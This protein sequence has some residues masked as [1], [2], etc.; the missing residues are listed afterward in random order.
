MKV[1]VYRNLR[2]KL[3][4]IKHKE[5]VI[6]YANNVLIKDAKFPVLPSGLKNARKTEQRNVHAFVEGVIASKDVDIGIDEMRRASYHYSV[7]YFYDC[8]TK[9]KLQ[10]GVTVYLCN[11]GMFYK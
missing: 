11:K 9:E 8:E 5:K 10:E 1:R 6:G 4:S 7:G 2:N 3:F